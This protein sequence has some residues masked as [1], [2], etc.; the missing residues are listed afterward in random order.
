VKCERYKR[1][2]YTKDNYTT[3]YYGCGKIGHVIA[4]CSR[5]DKLKKKKK[6][7]ASILLVLA[8]LPEYS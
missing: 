3:K 5:E 7:E 6:R 8:S 4:N 1:R 2:R